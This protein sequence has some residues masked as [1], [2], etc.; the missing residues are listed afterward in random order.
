MEGTTC[1]TTLCAAGTICVLAGGKLEW[2]TTNTYTDYVLSSTLPMEVRHGISEGGL[3]F[4]PYA[5][6]RLLGLDYR[7]AEEI[8]YNCDDLD[9][10]KEV[11]VPLIEAAEEAEYRKVKAET[12]PV[13]HQIFADMGARS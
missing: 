13:R 9:D 11:L 12:E 7:T 2:N 6:Q 4:I 1:R 10:I 8:F 5:A 3:T